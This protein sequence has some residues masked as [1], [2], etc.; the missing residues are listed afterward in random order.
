MDG[1]W[2]AVHIIQRVQEGN[3]W[4]STTI[5]NAMGREQWKWE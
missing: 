2:G 5:L 4:F 3:S 1:R